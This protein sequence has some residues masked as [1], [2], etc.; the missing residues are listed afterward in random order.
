MTDQMTSADIMSALRLRYPE[1]EYV[2]IPEAPQG[3]GRDGRKI[4]LLV[5]SMWRSRGHERDAIEVK[6]SMSDFRRELKQP[7]KADWWWKHVHRFFVAVPDSIADKAK[8]ELPTGW[9]LLSVRA[10]GDRRVAHIKVKPTTNR[11]AEPL[12]QQTVIGLLRAAEN[13]GP[14]ALMREYER[15]RTAGREEGKRDAVRLAAPTH[16]EAFERWQKQE[17]IFTEL[18][19]MRLSNVSERWGREVGEV[20][21]LLMK[22][23]SRPHDILQA[24]DRSVEEARRAARELEGVR[25]AAA[26]ALD[27]AA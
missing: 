2:H 12:P 14:S 1:S 17:A 20:V 11:D 23:G 13:A 10:D 26:K 5:I 9:G 8:A 24:F 6:V 27:G 4:D 25:E 16:S 7:E 18:T 15:G 3:A 19:G 21:K 22:W